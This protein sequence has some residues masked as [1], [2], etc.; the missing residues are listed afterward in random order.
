MNAGIDTLAR[1]LT[2]AQVFVPGLSFF[3]TF[4]AMTTKV[5]T[6]M[7]QLLQGSHRCSADKEG[8][9]ER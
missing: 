9:D 8:F 1:S 5:R 7:P 3:S 4:V 2:Q 6:Y